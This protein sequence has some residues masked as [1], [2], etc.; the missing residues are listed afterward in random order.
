MK[1]HQ[2]IKEDIKLTNHVI[3]HSC[4]KKLRNNYQISKNFGDSYLKR[5]NIEK[6]YDSN[7]S[8]TENEILKMTKKIYYLI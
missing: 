1:K 3:F 7:N 5:Q 4:K 2:K 8:S 6:E